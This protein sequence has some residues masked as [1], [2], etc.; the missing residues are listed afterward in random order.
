MRN[1]KEG[2]AMNYHKTHT[3]EVLD[4]VLLERIR[5][6][7]KWPDQDPPDGTGDPCFQLAATE[8]K[9]QCDFAFAHDRGSWRVILDEEVKEAFAE[10]DYPCLRAELIQVAAVAVAWVEA[11]DRR[12]RS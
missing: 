9:K 6:Q 1:T 8:A 11:I 7:A 12:V 5:Q 2:E 4:Q 3:T 10:T